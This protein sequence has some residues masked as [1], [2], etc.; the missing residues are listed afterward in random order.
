MLKIQNITHKYP[1]H[2][3]PILNHLD[4]ELQ[5][6]S[7]C[8]IIGSNGSG[9]S[10]LLKTI[11]GELKPQ[12]GKII[13][14]QKNITGLSIHKRAQ[15]LSS[16][17]QDIAKGTIAEMTLLENMSLSLLRGQKATFSSFKSAEKFFLQE[18]K[19]YKLGLEKHMHTKLSNLSGGQ[20]QLAAL[21]MASLAPPKL[22]LL[23]E[24][25][26]AL[27]PKTS[28]KLMQFTAN[29]IEKHHMTT[30]M[31]THNLSDAILYGDRIIM[32]HKGKIVIDLK[33]DAKKA[34][35]IKDLLDLFYHFENELLVNSAEGIE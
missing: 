16:V 8:V 15:F 6:G 33:D 10:T 32:L 26:S 20:R 12:K 25:S 4:L 5:E 21:I 35:T 1:L 7:F 27:D 34:L 30:L 24:H 9:K 17:T 28:Q 19:S 3:E 11:S 31:V 14:D 2:F 23:D 18:L 22:L 29:L 13:F